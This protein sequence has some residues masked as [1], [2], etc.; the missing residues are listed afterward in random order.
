MSPQNLD[1]VTSEL[2]S[3]VEILPRRLDER[4]GLKLADQYR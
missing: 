2:K 3:L 4:E 1:D